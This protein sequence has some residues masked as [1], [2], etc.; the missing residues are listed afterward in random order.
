MSLILF[1]AFINLVSASFAAG[2]GS[3]TLHSTLS[4]VA[5]TQASVPSNTSYA[6]PLF[7]GETIQLAKQALVA[8]AVGDSHSPL[9]SL[10]GLAADQVLA[11]EGL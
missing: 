11:L 6:P 4:F 7:Q 10:Y 5:T 3:K 1:I 2:P 8:A 9:S